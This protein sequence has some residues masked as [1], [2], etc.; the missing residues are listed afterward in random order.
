MDDIRVEV[1]K[2]V[3]EKRTRLGL[4]QKELA[5]DVGYTLQAIWNIEHGR[6]NPS[7]TTLLKLAHALY[8][9]LETLVSGKITITDAEIVHLLDGL[10]KAVNV[11]RERFAYYWG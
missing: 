11:Y 10:A 1:G 3:R 5:H 7:L 2:R 9:P 4:T 8:V 6:S